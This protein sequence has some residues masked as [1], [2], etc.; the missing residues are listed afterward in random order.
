[1]NF[2]SRSGARL[3]SISS[4]PDGG[5]ATA[6]M[7][8]KTTVLIEIS[9]EHDIMIKKNKLSAYLASIA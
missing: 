4:E 6:Q 3:T 7:Y 5:N 9:S 2:K 1:M 8:V